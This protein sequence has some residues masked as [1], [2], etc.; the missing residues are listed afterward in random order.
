M[1][2]QFPI[3]GRAMLG[4]QLG[5]VVLLFLLIAL[6]PPPRGPMVLAPLRGQR[7]AAL[8]NFAG[9]RGATVLGRGPLPGSL[10]IDGER[11]RL[12][13]PARASAMLLLAAPGVGWCGGHGEAR[14]W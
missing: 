6:A 10:V 13:S 3:T 7:L 8:I 14:E 1:G 11:R 4:V 5:G 2:Q 12:W 9:A